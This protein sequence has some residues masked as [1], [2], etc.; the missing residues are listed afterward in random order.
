[1]MTPLLV[2]GIA[3]MVTSTV[4]AFLVAAGA[5]RLRKRRRARGVGGFLPPVSLLKP[6]HGSEPDLE[7]HL[8][9]FFEQDYPQFEV[10]FCARTEQDAG[11]A[12]ARKVAARFPAIPC[13]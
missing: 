3:G 2:I 6:L 7:Q 8:Q 10:L 13:R 12:I 1:M 5:V 11:L 4:Y 9:S